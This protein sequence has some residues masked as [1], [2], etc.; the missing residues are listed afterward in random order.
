MEETDNV[1]DHINAMSVIAKHLAGLD[2]SIP[3]Q[4]Q[5]ETVINSLLASWEFVVVSLN[6]FAVVLIMNTLTVKLNI[7]TQRN[8][9]YGRKCG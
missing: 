8:P 5:V 3:D 2:C 9:G 4:L 1:V 6:M 7:E